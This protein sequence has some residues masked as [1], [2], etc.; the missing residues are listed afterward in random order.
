MNELESRASKAY[1]LSVA[2]YP[3]YE[4]S[5]ML[6]IAAMEVHHLISEERERM[7]QYIPEEERNHRLL[8]EADRL[9]N[10]QSAYWASAMAGDTKDAELVLKIMDRRSKLFGLDRPTEGGLT[11][12]AILIAGGTREEFMEA[13]ESAQKQRAAGADI[14]DAEVIE[15]DEE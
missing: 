14:V 2:G 3:N 6:N 4:I 7:A 15:E 8:L 1:A 9:D 12:R 5:K 10:L 13:L 11:T